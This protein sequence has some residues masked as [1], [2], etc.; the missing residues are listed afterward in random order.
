MSSRASKRLAEKSPVESEDAKG[1]GKK[2]TGKKGTGKKASAKKASAKKNT[3]KK[4]STKKASPVKNASNKK[5]TGKKGTRK[6]AEPAAVEEDESSSSKEGTR[7]KSGSGKKKGSNKKSAPAKK[8]SNQK[9]QGDITHNHPILGVINENA[10]YSVDAAGESVSGQ[11]LRHLFIDND[12]SCIFVRSTS[13]RV[14]SVVVVPDDVYKEHKT[15]YNICSAYSL[16]KDLVERLRQADTLFVPFTRGLRLVAKDTRHAILSAMKLKKKDVAAFDK[17]YESAT[18]I[19]QG[20]VYWYGNEIGTKSVCDIL[21]GADVVPKSTQARQAHEQTFEHDDHQHEAI[22][23]GSVPDFSLYKNHRCTIVNLDQL[24]VFQPLAVE[25]RLSVA[26]R[27]LNKKGQT[28]IYSHQRQLHGSTAGWAESEKDRNRRMQQA[29][30]SSG[31]S[32][33]VDY[34]SDEDEDEDETGIA[35]QVASMKL[36]PSA[37]RR[38]GGHGESDMV[39]WTNHLIF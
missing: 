33:D 25:T 1:T 13:K 9:P 10:Q 14:P 18:V 29:A 27:K 21:R 34:E 5:G 26:L 22:V 8:K 39:S 6:K 35:D 19:T 30:A 16:H 28:E 11:Q 20:P 17:K 37:R 23:I 36:H 4:G 24:F 3:G 31:S 15:P 12:I 32:F 38:T 2:G 7:K